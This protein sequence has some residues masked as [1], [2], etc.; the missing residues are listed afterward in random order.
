L[1]E[2]VQQREENN[3]MANESGSIVPQLMCPAK[4]NNFSKLPATTAIHTELLTG[5]V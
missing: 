4:G 2:A 3:E 5:G 1:P